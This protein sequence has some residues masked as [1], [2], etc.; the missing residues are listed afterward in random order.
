[1]GAAEPRHLI[2]LV[3]E[4]CVSGAS[5]AANKLGAVEKGPRGP[6]TGE[7]VFG[8]FAPH[9]GLALRDESNHRLRPSGRV[10]LQARR[11]G[12][13][14]SIYVHLLVPALYSL[15]SPPENNWLGS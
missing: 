1:M 5:C 6:R 11:A 14:P 12:A 13:K 7:M 8:S 15:I 10:N 4:H 3:G 9:N 2:R